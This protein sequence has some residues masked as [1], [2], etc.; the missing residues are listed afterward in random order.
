MSC[1]IRDYEKLCCGGVRPFWPTGQVNNGYTRRVDGRFVRQDGLDL[2]SGFRNRLL[3]QPNGSVAA[4]QI[5]DLNE[6]ALCK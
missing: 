6:P 2:T 3:V 4:S 1:E 5:N